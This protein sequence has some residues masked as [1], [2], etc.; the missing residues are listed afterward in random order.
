MLS[1]E[2]VSLLGLQKDVEKDITNAKQDRE[3]VEE[4]TMAYFKFLELYQNLAERLEKI[5]SLEERD[6]RIR[7]IFLNFTVDRQNVLSYK[8][9]QPFER[10]ISTQN[11]EK[12]LD[13]RDDRT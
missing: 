8:L 3:K 12:V 13:G 11:K 2:L 7:K 5:D 1:D 10:L 6:K 9:K 4:A